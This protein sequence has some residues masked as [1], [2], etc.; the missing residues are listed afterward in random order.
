MREATCI[1]L[2]IKPHRVWLKAEKAENECG[3]RG[4]ELIALLSLSFLNTDR[5]DLS[6]YGL[7]EQI[8]TPCDPQGDPCDLFLLSG[9]LSLNQEY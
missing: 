9:Y 6:K 1:Y 5:T 8:H 3:P 7:V 2:R 4:L